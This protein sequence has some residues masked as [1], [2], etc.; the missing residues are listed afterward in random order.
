MRPQ[1][2]AAVSNAV[3]YANGVVGSEQ[4]VDPSVLND[5]GVYPPADVK[6]KLYADVADTEDTTRLM[7]RMWTRFM[8]GR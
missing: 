4:Y 8:T 2:I 5:P 1:V 3:N 7:T 6:A